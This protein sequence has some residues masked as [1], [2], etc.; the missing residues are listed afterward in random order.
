MKGYT[1]FNRRGQHTAEYAIVFA[2]VIAAAVGMQP[3]IKRAIQAR[4]K[5]A[6]KAMVGAT[7]GAVVANQTLGSDAQYEPYYTNSQGDVARLSRTE[8]TRDASGN[9]DRQERGRNVRATGAFDNTEGAAQLGDD[10]AWTGS[11]LQ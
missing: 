11:T 6:T 7:S 8:E 9:T 10:N 1:I 5:D 3:L 2:I 4:M